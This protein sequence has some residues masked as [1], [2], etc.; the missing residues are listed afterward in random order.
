MLHKKLED[1]NILDNFMF[2]ELLDY[3]EKEGVKVC[4]Y[5]L[6]TILQ[7]DYKKIRIMTQKNIA[8][9]TPKN[10]GIR[11]DAYIEA[12]DEDLTDETS[13]E[14]EVSISSDIF[15]IEP[16]KYQA[17]NE[18]KRTRYYHSLI[19]TKVLKSGIHY[20]KL[21]NVAVIMILP[22]DP[23][24]KNRM[25]YTI[26]SKCIEDGTIGYDDGLTTIYLYTKGTEGNPSQELKDMLKYIENSTEENA[27]NE[28]LA[29]MHGLI[30]RIKHDGEVGV[31]YMQSWERE[32][33][34]REE[35]Y[36]DGFSEGK[37]QGELQGKIKSILELLQDIGPIPDD[38]SNTIQMETDTNKLSVWNKLAAKSE[39]IE[40]FREKAG[41]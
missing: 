18:A 30:N 31:R 41:I 35:G 5:M 19:D 15:D 29:A 24:G 10:H 8:G 28:D 6:R 27:V 34:V 9:V 16:N 32:A 38:L 36:K 23:F 3:D 25:V 26:K 21:Q 39:N 20:E 40:M 13:E 1:L 11:L 14:S 22:Y 12:S 33:M 4:R 17:H 7:K 2:N 37:F